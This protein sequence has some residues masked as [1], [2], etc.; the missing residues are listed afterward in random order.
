[1]VWLHTER[2]LEYIT[3]KVLFDIIIKFNLVS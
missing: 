3:Y 1:M 2:N